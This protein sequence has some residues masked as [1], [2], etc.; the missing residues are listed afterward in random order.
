MADK[1]LGVDDEEERAL[2]EIDKI[3]RKFSRE[4]DGTVMFL[5]A[6]S[7]LVLAGIAALTIDISRQA[8]ASLELDHLT[9]IACMRMGAAV[10]RDPS[11][12]GRRA[13]AA[14]I[15][16]GQRNMAKPSNTNAGNGQAGNGGAQS[17]DGWERTIEFTTNGA[18]DALVAEASAPTALGRILGINSLS[19]T[20]EMEC[21]ILPEPAVEETVVFEDSFEDEPG[22]RSWTVRQQTSKWYTVYG[23]GIELQ[24]SAV[25]AAQDGV[26]YVELDSHS[27][28]RFRNIGRR[29][30]TRMA[31]DLQLEPGQY[32]LS[33]WY[34]SR[35]RAPLSNGIHVT[36]GPKNERLIGQGV[37]HVNRNYQWVER[38][39]P[40][41]VTSAGEY[42]L[43]F[44]ATGR[45][46]SYGGFI[47]NVRVTKSTQGVVW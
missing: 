7:L 22:F 32:T 33:Y 20:S 36:F 9:E 17:R 29:T 42:R 35:T 6:A 12:D 18:N 40:L 24:A 34:R 15:F 8:S 47:D 10:Q 2:N 16:T 19:V 21:D 1:I 45:A 28:W 37:D 39:V 46:D 5:G 41:N 44:A 38:I 43:T 14:E 3:L 11:R 13:A 23:A 25:V 27:A 4:D 30:N 26:N 31:T